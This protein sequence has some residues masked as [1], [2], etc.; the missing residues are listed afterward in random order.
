MKRLKKLSGRELLGRRSHSVVSARAGF[1]L[2]ELL[3]VIAI[4]AVLV[5]LLLPAVQQAREAARRSQCVNNLKQVGLGIH[6]F[7]DTFTYLPTSNRPF[8]ANT[9]RLG[10]ITRML[11]YLEQSTLYNNYNQ[12]VNWD[13]GGNLAV[14]SVRIKTLECP[15]DV[16]LGQFDGDP[17]TSTSPGGAAYSPTLVATSSYAPVKGVDKAVAGLVTTITLGSLF[18]D[19]NKATNQY[20]AGLLPQNSPARLADVTDGLSNTIAF[21]ESAG[22]PGSFIQGPKQVGSAQ[23]NRVNGGGW[24]RPASDLLFAGELAGSNPAKVGGTVAINANNGFDVAQGSAAAA[25][26]YSPYGTEG[27]SQPFAFHPAGA[28]ALL[29][30]GSVR[31]LSANID[32]NVF[33]SAM[34]RGNGES[35]GL[36]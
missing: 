14:T 26:P 27:T 18:T 10:V 11:P 30:D 3:V 17:D 1:T 31:F 15:S 5:A 22:R 29:A 6:N 2:I 12:T 34:T 25:Y 7:H 24:C 33:V 4:I 19:P 36:Q 20:Y 13:Q 9:V 28:N 21:I 16:T 32:F 8:A 35:L 23:T